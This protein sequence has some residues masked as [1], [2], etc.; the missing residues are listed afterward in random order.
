M[1][2]LIMGLGLHGGGFESALFPARRGAELTITD[3]R[4]E[5]TLAPSI[6]NL[7]RPAGQRGRAASVMFWAV[8]MS[9]QCTALREIIKQGKTKE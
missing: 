5:K 3:L 1:K 2:A 4:D 9:P 7:K 8:T 6:E